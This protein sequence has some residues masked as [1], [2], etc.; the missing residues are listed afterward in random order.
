MTGHRIQLT[1]RGVLNEDY[2]QMSSVGKA[3][4]RR[5]LKTDYWRDLTAAKRREAGEQCERCG[6]TEHLQCHHKVYPADWYQTEL[7]MLEVLC[8]QCHEE[9]H[10]GKAFRFFPYREDE[11]FNRY[12]HRFHRLNE[13]ITHRRVPLRPRDESFL[14]HALKVYPPGPKDTAVEFQV[15]LIR[16]LNAFLLEGKI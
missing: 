7:G 10:F 3:A 6:S 13:R 12:C 14:D 2:G 15:G 8:R 4:Y 1:G 16:K 9:E 5:F 11:R